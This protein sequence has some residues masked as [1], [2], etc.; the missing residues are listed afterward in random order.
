MV[1]SLTHELVHSSEMN[2]IRVQVLATLTSNVHSKTCRHRY[3]P[4]H[5]KFKSNL[6]LHGVGVPTQAIKHMDSGKWCSTWC[7]LDDRP[8]NQSPQESGHI[9]GGWQ[10]PAVNIRVPLRPGEGESAEGQAQPLPF[11]AAKQVYKFMGLPSYL[12]PGRV[13]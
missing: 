9:L 10:A 12:V 6:K 1:C 5:S 7:V 4:I 13:S 8:S 3:D 2:K 11:T